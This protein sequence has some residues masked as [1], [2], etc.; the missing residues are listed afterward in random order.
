MHHLEWLGAST[1]QLIT[2]NCIYP[3][4]Q[5]NDIHSDHIWGNAQGKDQKHGVLGSDFPYIKRPLWSGEPLEFFVPKAV[6][7]LEGLFVQ[8]S[9]FRIQ[10]IMYIIYN[11]IYNESNI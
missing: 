7:S 10:Y 6:M 3:L 5:T 2:K 4:I 1:F 9:H 11:L 8:I